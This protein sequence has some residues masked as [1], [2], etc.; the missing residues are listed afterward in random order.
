MRGTRGRRWLALAVAAVIAVAGAP[1]ARALTVPTTKVPTGPAEPVPKVWGDAVPAFPGDIVVHQPDGSTFKANLTNAEIGGHLEV[2]GYTVTKR[3]DG[4]WTYA[5]EGAGGDGVTATASRVGLDARSATLAPGIGRTPNVWAGPNGVDLRTAM[6]DQL[7]AASW[8]AQAQA[9]EAGGPRLFRFPVL[10]LATWWDAEAGQTGPQFQEGHDPEFFRKLLDGFGGNRHGTLTEFYF[11][12]SFGQFLVQV[13]VYGPYTSQRSRQDR[14]YYGDIEAPDDPLDDL[15][16]L[17]TELG[18]GGGGAIG[19][20]AEAVPQADK[21]VDFSQYDNDGDGFVD[22]TAILHSGPDMSATG[23]PC[24]TWSHAAQVSIA[25]TI[26]EQQAGLPPGSARTGIPTTDGVQVDRVFTMPETDLEIGVAA[27]EMAHALGEPDYYNPSYTS[28]GTGDWD[29]MA[30]GSWF[31]NPPGSNPTGFNPASRVFQ[32]WITPTVVHDDVRNVTLQPRELTPTAGYTADQ[33]DPNVLLVPTQWIKVGDTDQYEHTWT[34][35]DVYG[36]V[37]DG[38][39]GYVVEGFYVENWSRSVNSPPIHE[40][41]TRAP[42]FDRQA[43]ASGAMAWHF[44]YVK[45]SSTYFGAPNNAGSDFNR[46]QM[47]PLEWDRNDNTQELQLGLTRGEPEDLMWDAATGITSGTRQLP[48]LPGLEGEPQA[49]SEF[50]GAVVPGTTSDNP[51]TVDDNPANYQLTVTAGGMGDCTLEVLHVV[52]GEEQSMGGT[53]D[54]G[55]V[56]DEEVIRITQPPPGDYIARVGDFAACGQYAGTIEFSSPAEI[57]WTTGAADTWSNWSQKPTGWAITNVARG[58]AENLDHQ[59]DAP[60]P[61]AITLDVIRVDDGET[62]V[63]PGYVT[64]VANAAGGTDPVTA[65]KATPFR[66]PVFNNGGDTARDVAVTV[67]RSTASGTV[68]ARGTVTVPPY[69]HTDFPFRATLP[70]E[71]PAKLVT[72]LAPGANDDQD[73]GNNT[74]ATDL[75][76]GPKSPRVLVVDDDGSTDAEASA[77]G[78]LAA[79]GIPYAVARNHVTAGTM[80]AYEAVVWE[81]GLERYQGQMDPTDRAEVAQ[82][83]DGGGKLLYASPRSAAALG[84]PVSRTN[85]LGTADMA[86]FLAEYFGVQYLDT[87]QVGGGE[88]RGLGDLFGSSTYATDVFPG[89]PLQDVWKATDSEAGPVTPVAGWNKGGEDALMAVRLDAT[90]DYGGFGTVFLG[91]NLSQLQRA[92]DT[93]AVVGAVM[94]HFGVARGGYTAPSSPVIHHTDLR[95]RVAGIAAP[96]KAVV[97][98]GRSAPVLQYRAHGATSWTSVAMTAGRSPKTWQASIP[99]AAMTADGVEYRIVA[100]TVSEPKA[101]LAHLIGV[102]PVFF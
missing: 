7:R 37:Q 3:D 79:L 40:D 58:P 69:S 78:A 89:R 86:P 75:W 60:G 29:I 70:A 20:A 48:P 19:M 52:D 61:E 85:P 35:N 39:R 56:G 24:H 36:L 51:F 73:A 43:L 102:A 55:A 4:W 45:R 67:R 14:C 88:V 81:A 21:D 76:V 74:Q 92:D 6:L 30:G 34:E 90:A 82:Y 16:P 9:A 5:A 68:V 72:V 46:P 91:F 11:E 17:D 42:Y 8:K 99:A 13:D 53:A 23:D 93:V 26:V 94:D 10:M 54:S 15:D 80:Q 71:G 87:E 38:D 49:G 83:L 18:A 95:N 32:G 101:P 96:V 63:S 2:D 28:M 41:M 97:V 64:P 62:D 84:E 25:S 27:H 33:P 47:D 77:T 22:F 100:G 65:G 59:A 31:G 57:F 1:V 98:G 66:V 44:D 50:S 12:N